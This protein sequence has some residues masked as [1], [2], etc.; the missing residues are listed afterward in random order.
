MGISWCRLAKRYEEDI[1]K[2]KA[3]FVV[4]NLNL[5]VEDIRNEVDLKRKYDSEDP[6][7]LMF[8]RGS[9]SV[10]YENLDA[11]QIWEE[12]KGKVALLHENFSLMHSAQPDTDIL[13]LAKSIS[14]KGVFLLSS[15]NYYR[16]AVNYLK[17]SMK[18]EIN[19]GFEHGIK[20]AGKVL[21]EVQGSFKFY[22]IF[23]GRRFDTSVFDQKF[24]TEVD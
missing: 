24:E 21:D 14:N 23:A 4:T 17:N 5:S 19:T 16:S 7:Y 2:G 18:D 3:K 9:S 6:D 10:Q 15:T 11:R 22:R 20:N 8:Q 13:L 1:K 12:Y